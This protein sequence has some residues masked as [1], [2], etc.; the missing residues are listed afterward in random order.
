[1]EDSMT[2][3]FVPAPPLRIVGTPGGPLE[4]LTFAAKDLFDVAGRPTGGGNPDWALSWADLNGGP[5]I[6]EVRGR[7]AMTL[8]T[9]LNY[10]TFA[11][12]SAP[13]VRAQVRRAVAEGG[14]T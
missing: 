10:V 4:G 1:M 3:P 2:S 7:T 9:G 5:S 14:S 12:E 8:M 6:A 13:S 11:E